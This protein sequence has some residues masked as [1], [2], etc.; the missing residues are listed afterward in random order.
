MLS[1]HFSYGSFG[2]NPQNVTLFGQSAGAASTALHMLSPSSQG[3]FHKVILES[4][5]A[6]AQ[7]SVTESIQKAKADSE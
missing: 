3:L 1:S 5:T 4:G 6:V 2:G 7:W